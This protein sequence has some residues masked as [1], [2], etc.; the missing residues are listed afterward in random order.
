M[1]SDP[2]VGLPANLN[3]DGFPGAPAQRK[4]LR[5]DRIPLPL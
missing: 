4:S 2:L 1:R 5:T 3:D